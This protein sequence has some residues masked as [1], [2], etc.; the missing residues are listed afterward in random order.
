MAIQVRSFRFPDHHRYSID[1][2]HAVS[3]EALA[4]GLD[5]VVTTEKDEVKLEPGAWPGQPQLWVLPV[6]MK[7]EPAVDFKKMIE[8]VAVS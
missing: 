5:A 4:L 7:V 2:L 8:G 6:K 3:I 1:D